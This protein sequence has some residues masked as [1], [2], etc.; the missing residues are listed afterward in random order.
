ME[1]LGGNWFD[2]LSAWE[3]WGQLQQA[4]IGSSLTPEVEAEQAAAKGVS[5]DSEVPMLR[6]N[7]RTL[8]GAT[9][10]QYTAILTQRDALITALEQLL[11]THDA[12]VCPVAAMPAIPHCEPGTPITVEGHAIPYRMATLAHTCPF[13][14]TGQ[15]VAVLPVTLSRDGLPIGIQVVGRR[16]GDI[17]LLALAARLVE[18]VGP[19][20]RP[21][22]YEEGA[23]GAVASLSESGKRL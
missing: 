9:M 4:E 10:R 13:N 1:Q 11:A 23:I 16:W 21:S 6:G 17:Q 8:G 20:R 18:V 19:F 12:L 22:G 2:F 3:T 14:L 5:L 15:P 7:A